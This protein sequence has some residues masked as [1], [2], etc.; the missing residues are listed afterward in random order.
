MV[1]QLG[2]HSYK[3]KFT[4]YNDISVYSYLAHLRIDP[5]N[6]KIWA[7]R[8][9]DFHGILSLNQGFWFYTE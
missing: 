9:P 5:E 6:L 2:V 7:I 3:L 1:K 8:I 4:G